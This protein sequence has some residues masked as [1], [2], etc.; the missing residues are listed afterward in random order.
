MAEFRDQDLS[1]AR[2]E[3]VGL[4]GATFT[5]VD[6]REVRIRGAVLH[7]SRLRGVELADVE[8]NGELRNVVVNGVDIAPLVEAELDRR[9]PDRAKMRAGDPDGLR[10]AWAVLERLWAGTLARAR[11]FPE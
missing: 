11:T 3:R 4:R 8:L 1:G 7:G 9:T 6:L 10:V 2:F 5:A